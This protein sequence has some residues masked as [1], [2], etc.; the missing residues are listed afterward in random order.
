MNP[1]N[2][3]GTPPAEARGGGGAG[4]PLS[5][6]GPAGPPKKP[7]FWSRAKAF[8][9]RRDSDEDYEK[10]PNIFHDPATGSTFLPTGYKPWLKSVN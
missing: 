6:W 2:P 8:F 7:T 9:D 1:A 5:Y 4:Q 10:N 3:S